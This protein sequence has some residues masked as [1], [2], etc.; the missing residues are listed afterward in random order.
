MALG[1]SPRKD[2]FKKMG[3]EMHKNNSKTLGK[4]LNPSSPPEQRDIF[5]EVAE[6]VLSEE[7]KANLAC[8]SGDLPF[9]AAMVAAQKAAVKSVAVQ[10]NK[11]RTQETGGAMNKVTARDELRLAYAE[12]LLTEEEKADVEPSFLPPS[13]R[14][15]CSEKISADMTKTSRSEFLPN[16]ERYRSPK[17]PMDSGFFS[18][19]QF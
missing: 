10:D 5:R 11:R 13:M 4:K 2:S 6:K 7:E 3:T 15:R 17:T 14:L 16:L 19:V 18:R 9:A 1:A 8:V 12:K